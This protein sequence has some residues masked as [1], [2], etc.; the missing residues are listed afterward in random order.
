M[1]RGFRISLH[2]SSILLSCPN[3]ALY[4]PMLNNFTKN[5]SDFAR[6][7]EQISIIGVSLPSA[8][9]A[10]SLILSNLSNIK[11]SIAS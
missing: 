11:R 9:V 3:N 5:C 6:L 4:T 8:L 1:V 2:T 10:S 7:S